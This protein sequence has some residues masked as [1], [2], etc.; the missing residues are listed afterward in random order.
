MHLVVDGW[1]LH[2]PR[3]G[4]GVYTLEILSRLARDE[5]FESVRVLLGDKL[6]S[7]EVAVQLVD[8]PGFEPPPPVVTHVKK[9]RHRLSV[10]P[11]LGPSVR[12]ILK[13][14]RALRRDHRTTEDAFDRLEQIPRLLLHAPN[15]VSPSL[16]GQLVITVHDV[17]FLHYPEMHPAA[18]MEWLEEGLRGSMDYAAK[19]IV[20]SQFTRRELIEKFPEGD[21]DRIHVVPLGASPS[22]RPYDREESLSV[23]RR[24]GLEY[25]RYCLFVGNLEPRKNLSNLLHAWQSIPGTSNASVPLVLVGSSGWK[26]ADLLAQID[27]LAAAGLVKRLGFVPAEDLPVI[28]AG[29]KLFAYPSVYEGFGLPVL[30]AMACGVPVVTSD[31]TS[32]PE[33]AGDAAI[34]VDPENPE[35]IAAAIRRLLDDAELSAEMSAKGLARAAL[36]SWDKCVSETVT[37]YEEAMLLRQPA[38]LPDPPSAESA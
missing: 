3:S 13:R 28:T 26:N 29:A 30:E 37:V 1:A 12:K 10:V 31:R 20:P 23:L 33:V 4:I 24:H 7:F 14:Y 11:V 16:Q 21:P 27:T 25:G 5:T 35:E 38:S 36:Y 8:M 34:L 22:F 18:R 2:P 32:L 9:V 19:I 15:F 6:V 17:S